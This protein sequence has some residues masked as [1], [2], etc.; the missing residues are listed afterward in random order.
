M[1]GICDERQASPAKCRRDFGNRQW[2][3]CRPGFD[4]GEKSARGWSGG[5]SAG[6]GVFRSAEMD[7]IEAPL[8]LMPPT[9]QPA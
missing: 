5:F 7:G 8:I 9:T 4:L 3:L 1:G 6:L 2:I